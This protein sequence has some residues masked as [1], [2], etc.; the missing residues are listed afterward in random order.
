MTLGTE[1]IRPER[2][3]E[4]APPP[5]V[6]TA[7]RVSAAEGW[8]A[9]AAFL[10]LLAAGAGVFVGSTYSSEPLSTQAMLR[11]YDLVTATLALP[12]LTGSLVC[13][14]RGSSWARLVCAALLAYLVYTYAYYLLGT[15]YG[16]LLP[17]HAAL[18]ASAAIGLIGQLTTLDR[19]PFAGWLQGRG[20]VRG[21]A[22]VLGL[23]AAALGGMWIYTSLDAATT[24]TVPAGSQLV[25]SAPIVHLGIALD[26]SL[27][28]PLYAGAAVLLVRR[29]TWGYVLAAVSVV[30]GIL[31]QLTYIVA[32]PFQLAA[33]VPGA[34]AHDPGEPIIVAVYLLAG[35]LLIGGRRRGHPRPDTEQRRQAAVAA[36][37]PGEA[38]AAPSGRA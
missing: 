33:G 26:L 25:E 8:A 23:L 4:T 3:L 18:I 10:T 27:L 16:I 15:G 37:R 13:A 7:P 11:G 29:S 19:N 35:Y 34:V 36:A 32:M 9:V 2:D 24:G 20:R 17:L 30:A 5:R 28:V 21:V 1:V 6:G 12:L 14:R 38:P 31:H 22:T